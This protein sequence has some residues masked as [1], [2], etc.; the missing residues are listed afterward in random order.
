MTE[1]VRKYPSLRSTLNRP[2]PTG[3]LELESKSRVEDENRADELWWW[4]E[5]KLRRFETVG[6]GYVCY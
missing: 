5:A 3:Q 1:R 6:L 4:E 2:G